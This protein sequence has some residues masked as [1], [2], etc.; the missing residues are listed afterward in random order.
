MK[1]S[2]PPRRPATTPT[3]TPIA[4]AASTSGVSLT[5]ASEGDVDGDAAEEDSVDDAEVVDVVVSVVD[6]GEDEEE[7]EDSVSVLVVSGVVDVPV[8]VVEGM[9]KSPRVTFSIP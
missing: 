2:A 6:E 8:V 7:E 4:P 1:S 3:G 5:L 9:T